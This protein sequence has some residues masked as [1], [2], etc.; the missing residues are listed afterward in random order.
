MKHRRRT[1]SAPE[2]VGKRKSPGGRRFGPRRGVRLR[3]EQPQI[4]RIRRRLVAYVVAVEVVAEVIAFADF[5]RVGGVGEGGV[6]AD[7]AVEAPEWTIQSL[8]F[9]RAAS[10]AGDQ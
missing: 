7:H 10:P 6:E 1:V 4:D 2:R 8:I 9:S 3:P 5:L